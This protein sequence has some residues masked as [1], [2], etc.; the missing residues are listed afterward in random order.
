[1]KF[2]STLRL[3]REF[4]KVYRRGSYLPGKY[5]VLHFIRH[6]R[7]SGRLGITTGRKVKGSVRRNRIRRLLRECYRLNEAHIRKGYDIV[8]LGR[9]NPGDVR[10][11]QVEKDFIQLMKRAG[12]WDAGPAQGPVPPEVPEDGPGRCGGSAQG[13]EV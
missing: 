13:D 9:D 4:S 11:S 6:G 3:N 8:L 7:D 2:T 5:L 10:Y 1:M 12:I